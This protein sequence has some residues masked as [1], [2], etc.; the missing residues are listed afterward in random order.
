MLNAE[1]I[2][3]RRT[4][5]QYVSPGDDQSLS[6]I[7]DIFKYQIDRNLDDLKQA[8]SANDI[9]LIDRALHKMKG[10]TA[11][12]GAEHMRSLTCQ[13]MDTPVEQRLPVAHNLLTEL[14]VGLQKT[15]EA[16]RSIP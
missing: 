1:N 5:S 14:E 4:F 15:I 9:T 16:M 13:A 11:F 6:R 12:I 3:D 2:L 10:T 8:L 7:L